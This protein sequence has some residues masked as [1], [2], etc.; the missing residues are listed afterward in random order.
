MQFSARE[1]ISAPIEHVFVAVSDFDGFERQI[2]RRGAEIQRKDPSGGAGIGSEWK[3]KFEFRGKE[4]KVTARITE[5]DAPNGYKSSGKTGGLEGDFGVELVSL[6]PNRTRMTVSLDLTAKTLAG[7][8]L[9]QSLK[10]AKGNL[11]K[12]F[13]KRVFG[14]AQGIEAKYAQLG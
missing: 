4:R 3:A 1:D 5:F 10:F 2:L 8:L 6:S 7:R 14:F 9:V 11:S 12:R 13:S